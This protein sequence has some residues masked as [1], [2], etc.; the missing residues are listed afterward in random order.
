[1]LRW[2]NMRNHSVTGR[3]RKCI[4]SISP[5]SLVG[6]SPFFLTE[7]L[8]RLLWFESRGSYGG[9]RALRMLDGA[10]LVM[11]GIWRTGAFSCEAPFVYSDMIMPLYS[12]MITVDR[13][14]RRYKVLGARST[15]W[16]N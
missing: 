5:T 10:A 8:P 15:F 12:Q 1:M 4:Q 9:R 16:V 14:T 13:E 7:I 6:L 3:D 11:C 2:Q